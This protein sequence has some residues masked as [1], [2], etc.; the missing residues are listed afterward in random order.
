MKVAIIKY[1]AGNIYSVTSA[2]K[3]LGVEPIVTDD[4]QEIMDADCVIFPGVGEAESAMNYLKEKGLDTLIPTLKQPFLGVCLG[5]Q[6]LCQHSEEN[7]VDCF[8]TMAHDVK[9][10]PPEDK[11]PHMGWNTITSNPNHP[12]FKDLSKDAYFYFVHSY[13]VELGASTIAT[14]DYILP[15]TA[16]MQ[17]DNFYAV[18]F[19]P[20]KSGSDGETILK[21]FLA[22][23]PKA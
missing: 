6:L 11:V 20:E 15:F 14:T 7:D 17:K 8:G 10:F 21:N 2:F 19:H 18:Q 16:A 12:L 13:Y 22:L 9:R 23:V 5:M 1:V 4:H 3:R